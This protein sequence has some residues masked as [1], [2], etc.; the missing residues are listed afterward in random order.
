MTS[1]GYADESYYGKGEDPGA[2]SGLG[3]LV[4][5][6][7]GASVLRHRGLGSPPTGGVFAAGWGKLMV[8]DSTVRLPMT[9]FEKKKLE[10]KYYLLTHRA[11]SG[12]SSISWK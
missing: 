5:T 10:L 3:R 8:A 6:W 2:P 9:K 1:M 11:G 7:N 4:L 12:W